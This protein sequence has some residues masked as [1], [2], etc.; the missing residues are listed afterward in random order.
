MTHPGF[1]GGLGFEVQRVSPRLLSWWR[2]IAPH[3]HKWVEMRG[4]AKHIVGIC[5]KVLL[6]TM[7]IQTPSPP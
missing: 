2:L 1:S 3:L 6:F 5:I 7:N 4:D